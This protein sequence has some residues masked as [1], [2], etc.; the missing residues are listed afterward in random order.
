[1]GVVGC[2]G[3]VLSQGIMMREFERIGWERSPEK[4]M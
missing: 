2:G 3:H 4:A 1:M